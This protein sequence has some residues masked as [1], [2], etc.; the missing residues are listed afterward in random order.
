MDLRIATFNA[1]NS[2][3]SEWDHLW[4]R[5]RP[6]LLD[7]IRRL[8]ADVIGLQE[9]HEWQTR[10]LARKLGPGWSHVGVGRTRGGWLGEQV[11]LFWRRSRVTVRDST[12]RWFGDHPTRPGTV[13]P[14][15]SF[16]RITTA[17]QA[18]TVEG[19]RPFRVFNTHLDEHLAVNRCTATA[20]LRDWAAEST[21]PAVIVG[22]FNATLDTDE[23]AILLEAGFRSALSPGTG[24]TAHEYT[25]QVEGNAIDHVLVDGRWRVDH[26]L[27]DVRRPGGR[28]PSDH[29]PVVADLELDCTEGRRRPARRNRTLPGCEK[30]RP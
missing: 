17:V 11:P 9:A 14:G 24:R 25:G 12:T 6:V 3:G 1:R 2:L 5:R 8:D 29:W 21:D 27:I 23:L 30:L 16:P 28:L 26:A 18:R 10:W 4:W 7:A 20:Q 13:L 22:D 15:A 19:D